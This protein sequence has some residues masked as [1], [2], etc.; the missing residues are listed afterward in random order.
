MKE[1]FVISQCV[2]NDVPINASA[3]MQVGVQQR[4][5]QARANHHELRI[6]INQLTGPQ[7]RKPAERIFRL[8]NDKRS[9]TSRIAGNES[10]EMYQYTESSHLKGD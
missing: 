9:Q 6:T 10:P 1:R 2:V 3:R 7:D 5:Q 4:V 8:G